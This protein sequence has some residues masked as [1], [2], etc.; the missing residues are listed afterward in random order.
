MSATTLFHIDKVSN[1]F[2]GD[3]LVN[4]AA[5]ISALNLTHGLLLGPTASDCFTKNSL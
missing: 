5:N 2:E 3:A 4:L 1:H